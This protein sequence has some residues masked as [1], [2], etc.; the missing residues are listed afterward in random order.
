VFIW[1]NIKKNFPH[2]K[3]LFIKLRNYNVKDGYCVRD[4]LKGLNPRKKQWVL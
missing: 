4:M 1:K 2:L 3:I